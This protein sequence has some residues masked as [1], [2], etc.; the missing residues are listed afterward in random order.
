MYIYNIDVC[1]KFPSYTSDQ[2]PSVQTGLFQPRG[3]MY[4]HPY[5]LRERV[6]PIPSQGEEQGGQVL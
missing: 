6:I 1:I 2:Q 3:A 4:V 5:A